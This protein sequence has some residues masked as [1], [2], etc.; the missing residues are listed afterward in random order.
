MSQLPDGPQIPRFLQLLKWVATPCRF[1]DDCAQRYGDTFTL[2]LSRCNNFVFFSHPQAIQDIFT[3]DGKQFDSGR[4]SGILRPLVGENSLFLLDGD[5]H[6]RQRKLLM[7]PFHGER[8]QS[9]ARTIA[10]ITEGVASQ[11]MQGKPFTARRAMQDITLQVI[12]HAVFGL[13]EGSR[14]QQLKPLLAEVLDT[15]GSPLRSSALFF[16]ALQKD[17]GGWSPWGKMMQR[18]QQI[19]DLLQEEISE[20]RAQP[21][22][23]GK[24]V[25]S[26]MLSARDENGQP[27]TDVELRDEMLTL[28][29]AG[30]ETTATAL[31]WALYWVHKFPQVREKLREEIDSLGDHPDPL[32]IYRLPYLS[33]VC[34][35]TL[36]IYPVAPIAFGRFTN[37]PMEIMGR[38]YEANTLVTACI[39]LTHH[40]ED[41]YPEPNQFKP[42]RFIEHQYSPYEFIPFGGGNRRCLGAALAQLEMKLV[43]ATILSHYQL[44]LAENKPVKPQRRGVTIAPAGGVQMVMK[45]KRQVASRQFVTAS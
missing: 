23:Q 39:Y 13:S 20:R 4:A 33:A 7:P 38:Q 2:R 18:K 17:W 15:T 11:W 10:Q 41:L 42:D 12:L 29:F 22:L 16:P 44:E 19:H 8:M 35:E 14:Y 9:Y 21:E 3:A 26:L 43:L 34:N 45:G 40:R 6:K 37:S 36:R 28:L 5:R 30:H 32:A 31:A 24:D 1:L 25:L 27:M